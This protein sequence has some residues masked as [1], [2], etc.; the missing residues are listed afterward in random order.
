MFFSAGGSEDSSSTAGGSE[1][2][3]SKQVHLR[4]LLNPVRYESQEGDPSSL[5]SVVCERTFLEGKSGQQ[6]A[7]GSGAYETLAAQLVRLRMA[8]ENVCCIF[9]DA[10]NECVAYFTIGTCKYRLQGGPA[11][12]SRALLRRGARCCVKRAW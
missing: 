10:T 4:F 7:V 2:S 3:S 8:W 12:R 11:S 9:S 5:G 1:D 6:R